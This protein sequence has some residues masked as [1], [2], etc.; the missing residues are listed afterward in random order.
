VKA[1]NGNDGNTVIDP[2]T[3]AAESTTD[4]ISITAT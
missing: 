4:Q 3:G 1:Q 2:A